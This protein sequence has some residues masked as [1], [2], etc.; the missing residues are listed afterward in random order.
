LI[1][2]HPQRSFSSHSLNFLTN[3]YNHLIYITYNILALSKL[4][5][6]TDS[7]N[8]LYTLN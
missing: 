3:P 8:E 6:F 4:R 5:Y 2:I 7:S 1:A